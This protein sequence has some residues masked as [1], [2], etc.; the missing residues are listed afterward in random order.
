VIY[1]LME[2]FNPTEWVGIRGSF[3]GVANS[4]AT[5]VDGTFTGSFDYYVTAANATFPSGPVRTC[6]ADPQVQLRR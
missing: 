6:A 2:R 3:E 1:S 5:V 4:P